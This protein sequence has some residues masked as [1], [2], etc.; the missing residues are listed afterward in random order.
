MTTIDAIDLKIMR[1]LTVDGRLSI[2]DLAQS[3]GLSQTPTANRV[4]RLEQ[5]GLIKEYRAV[6]DETRLGGA[7]TAF[8]WI[9]LTDQAAESLANFEELMATSP[10]VM[11]CYLM[12]GDADYLARIAVDS[13]EEFEEFLTARISKS[14]AVASIRS[15]FALRAFHRNHQPPTLR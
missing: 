6:L 12:T 1:R 5:D 2:S 11:E 13:L 4:R 10:Q 3:V 7:M 9:S 15:S 14:K 8:T